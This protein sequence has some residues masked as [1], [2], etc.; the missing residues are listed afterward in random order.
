MARFIKALNASH[1]VPDGPE[2]ADA[3]HRALRHEGA[4]RAGHFD[5]EA[6]A[7]RLIEVD[8]DGEEH[9]GCRFLELEGAR[10]RLLVHD[11]HHAGNAVVAVHGD[12]DVFPVGAAKVE[13]TVDH[14]HR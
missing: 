10:H 12:G 7:D 3:E 5:V 8:I 9:A 14:F 13:R 1:A 2:R 11:T 4:R 6:I